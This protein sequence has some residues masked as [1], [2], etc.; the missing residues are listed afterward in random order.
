MM[1]L[2]Y[3]GSSMRIS[4]FILILIL[5]ATILTEFRKESG[6]RQINNDSI[7]DST[8]YSKMYNNLY[9]LNYRPVPSG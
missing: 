4:I 7:P 6:V 9:T 5:I 8:N 1:S 2:K 3:K